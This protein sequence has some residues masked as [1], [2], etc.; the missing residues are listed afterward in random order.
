MDNM[1]APKGR[2]R[3][4]GAGRAKGVPNKSTIELRALIA[5]KCGA[6]WDP[7]VEMARIAQTGAQPVWDPITDK[8]AVITDVDP[9]TGISF[10][11]PVT[12]PVSDKV[13]SM[14]RK[15]VAEYLHAKRKAVEMSGP[16]GDPIELRT[17][18]DAKAIETLGAMLSELDG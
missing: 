16:D 18:N 7:L 13:R 1:A 8:Q 6:D 11:I 9:D 17:H 3:P 15:E 5:E 2:P 14:C 12:I 4:V 10:T